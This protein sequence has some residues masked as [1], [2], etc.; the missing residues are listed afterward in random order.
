MP[1]RR[2]TTYPERSNSDIWL[3][4]QHI[5]A[6]SLP[7]PHIERV[8]DLQ[9]DHFLAR[10]AREDACTQ[11]ISVIYPLDGSKDEIVCAAAVMRLLA[12]SVTDCNIRGRLQGL[13]RSYGSH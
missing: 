6:D 10:I 4:T 7:P 11:M 2:N 12:P 5:R 1:N 13:G 9:P 3:L 8:P